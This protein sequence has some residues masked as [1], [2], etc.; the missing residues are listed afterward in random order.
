MAITAINDI[1]RELASMYKYFPRNILTSM[2]ALEFVIA[3]HKQSLDFLKY[4][5]INP[6]KRFHDDEFMDWQTFDHCAIAKESL[7]QYRQGK[8]NRL[9]RW[10]S[11]VIPNFHE[12]LI[13]QIRELYEDIRW[14]IVDKV[15]VVSILNFDG[16]IAC[17]MIDK[18]LN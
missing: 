2:E 5:G 12:C 9:I 4:F 7:F 8:L 13:S 6:E 11:R 16:V 17:V 10:F 18:E 15:K 3:K 1:L 14:F